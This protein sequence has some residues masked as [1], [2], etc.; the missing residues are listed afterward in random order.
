[1]DVGGKGRKKP[2]QSQRILVGEY[3]R[4]VVVVPAG[5]LLLGLDAPP[6][7]TAPSLQELG[8]HPA[9]CCP[10]GRCGAA[11]DTVQLRF[12]NKPERF[13]PALLVA[14][15]AIVYSPVSVQDFVVLDDDRMVYANPLYN[16]VTPAH[17]LQLWEHSYQEVY[18]PLAYTYWAVIAGLARFPTPVP[19]FGGGATSLNPH[20]FH[21]A[22]LLLHL[23]N[24]VLVFSLLRLLVRQHWAAAG[25]ALVF[26]LHPAQVEGVAWISAM[27]GLL[28]GTF[29]LLA[30]RQYLTFAAVRKQ[31]GRWGRRSYL[32]ATLFFLLA[33]L[34]KPEAVAIP[35]AA[36]VLAQW[37]ADLPRRDY[38]R[39]L[40]PW[41]AV[42]LLWIP[43]TTSPETGRSASLFLPFWERFL[44]AGDTV[45]FYLYKLFLP[46]NLSVDYGRSPSFV[47][48]HSWGY[49]TWLIPF[50]L[51]VA[52][53]RLR[54]RR[55]WLAVSAG[56][57]LTFLLPTL[58]FVP[59]V[60]QHYSTAADRYLYLALLG[61]SLAVA[62]FLTRHRGRLVLLT[63][64][65]IIV[66]WASLSFAQVE[67]WDN[68]A[69]VLEQALSV[70]PDIGPEQDNY[71]LLLA[72]QGR[73]PEATMHLQQAIRLGANDLTT[74]STLALLLVKQGRTAEATDQLLEAVRLAPGDVNVRLNLAGLLASQGR[75][76]EAIT[77]YQEALHLA[78][79]N[80]TARVGM[81]T[82]LGK[83]NHQGR[84]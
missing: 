81:G 4:Q 75:K 69:T 37:Y 13:I 50:A 55:P 27:H 22:S 10:A 2:H 1:M 61:P 3:P 76:S 36:W 60:F 53:W 44:V 33:L 40:G 74:R 54:K 7:R 67:T 80:E 17:L 8:G 24:T 21:L 6:V 65:G 38:V 79:S 77:Q 45:A 12:P 49:L 25:G 70:N 39:T 20:A 34:S 82:L 68:G 62:H 58:G 63:F 71:G 57:F 16:P 51:G 83:G 72:H 32:L 28:C 15:T 43:I 18:R 48:G 41:L 78:P 52:V 29:S 46:I 66:L 5:P 42:A 31:D 11:G 73:L 59:S 56:L 64:A 84:H 19:V 9:N 30:L 35:L 14:L 26:A 47:L 23:I